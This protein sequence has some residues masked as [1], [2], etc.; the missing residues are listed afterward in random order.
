MST[1]A[2]SEALVVGEGVRIWIRFS[3]T[4]TRQPADPLQP[5]TVT[6]DPPA[7]DPLPATRTLTA[8]RDRRGVYYADTDA[9]IAGVWSY[10]GESSPPGPGV[11]EGV[12]EVQAS[13][14]R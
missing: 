3:D 14:L 8:T 7:V 9:D 11:V 1:T 10:R 13:R 6:V 2:D 5:V 4:E 12:F